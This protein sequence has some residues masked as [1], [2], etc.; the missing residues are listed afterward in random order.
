MG[1]ITR[2]QLVDLGRMRALR[3][4]LAIALLV[5]E[6]CAVS[7]KPSLAH[8]IEV[9]NEAHRPLFVMFSARWCAPCRAFERNVLADARVQAALSEV[10]LA[11][12]DI[13]TDNGADAKQRCGVHRIPDVVGI[14][15][16]GTVQA[17]WEDG[18]RSGE[19]TA[20]TADEFLVFVRETRQ[21]IERL[22]GAAGSAPP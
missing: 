20:L 15:H 4:L 13:D 8:L 11:V 1:K 3:A 12:F 17:R 5:A 18:D 2:L 6:A 14:D 9:T 16:D 19:T 10:A 22:A 21:R 7:P